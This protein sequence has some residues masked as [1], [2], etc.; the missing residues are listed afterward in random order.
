MSKTPK[1]KKT[2]KSRKRKGVASG[3]RPPVRVNQSIAGAA[4]DNVV[5]IIGQGRVPER[6]REIAVSAFFLAEH[7]TRR[8]EAEQTLPQPVACQEGC[9]SCCYNRVEL[10][11]PEALLLGYYIAQQFSEAQKDLLLAHV[12]RIIQLIDGMGQTER[13]ARRRE[14]PCPLLRNRTCSVYSVRPLVCRAMHSLDRERCEAELRTGCLAGSTYYPHRHEIAVSVSAGL[15]EGCR[16]A[17]LQ[18]GALNI[19]LA[20]RD[21]FSQE[22]PVERWLKGEEV[23]GG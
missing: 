20:L 7:L 12:T 10:T 4:K 14:I 18:S 11:P 9:D 16:T 13:A 21:F 2:K 17:G 19:A 1:R 6:A 5:M 15:R 8:L 22:N 23:F 3:G